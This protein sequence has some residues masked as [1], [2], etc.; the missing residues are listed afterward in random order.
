MVYKLSVPNAILSA[1]KFPVRCGVST[2]SLSCQLKLS[3]TNAILSVHNI[4]CDTW[5]GVVYKLSATNAIL[6]VNIFFC[7]KRIWVV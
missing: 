3:V 7:D 4:L 5:I 6:L 1:N 2:W